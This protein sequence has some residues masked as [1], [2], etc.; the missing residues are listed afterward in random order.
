MHHHGASDLA[1][2]LTV[3]IDGSASD[4]TLTA[5]LGYAFQYV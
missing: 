4:W 5:L 2:T 3:H 1:C